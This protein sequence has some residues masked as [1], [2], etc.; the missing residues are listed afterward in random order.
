VDNYLSVGARTWLT[1][2][3]APWTK[4]YE[5]WKE[6]ANAL[7]RGYNSAG[8]EAWTIPCLYVTGKY[9]RLFAIRADKETQKFGKFGA[10]FQDDFDPESG[11]NDQLEDAARVLNRM[12]QTC[13][14]DR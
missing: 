8:F 7:I 13:I 10:D 14:T 3:Q 9:L 1:T 4:V 2:V 11:K 5:A 12:F 6:M